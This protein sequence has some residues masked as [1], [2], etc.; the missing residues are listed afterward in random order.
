LKVERKAFAYITR[1]NHLLVFTQPDPITGIPQAEAGIQVP[2]GTI[3][4]NETPEEAAIREASE[5]T[6]LSNLK[7]SD[8]LGDMKYEYDFSVYGEEVTHHRYFFHFICEE[9]TPNSWETIERD[10][11]TDPGHV[12]KFQFYW[13]P[14]NKQFP[15]LIAGQGLMIAKLLIVL[16]NQR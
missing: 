7:I 8:F 16:G 2:A 14:L 15:E 6:G 12:I 5:E 13:V 9:K 3:E 11:S 4:D 10:P 1:E